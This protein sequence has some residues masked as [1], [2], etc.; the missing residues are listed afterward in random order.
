M[1]APRATMRLQLNAGFTFADAAT[2]LPYI[3]ALGVSHVYASP[4][5][6]ARL[7][8]MHGYDTIDPTRVNPELGAEEGLRQLVGEL[9]RHGMGL[10]VDIV[11]NHMATGSDNAWWMD[12]LARGRDSRYA[13]Y[14][15][16]DWAPDDPHLRG[17]VLSDPR[18]ALWRGFGRRRNRTAQRQR[19]QHLYPVFRPRISACGRQLR[20]R[21]AGF[22]CRLRSGVAAGRERLHRCSKSSAIVWLGGGSRMTKSIGAVSSTSTS[23]S[24]SAW[25]MTKCSRPFT[26]HC[27][28]FTPRVSSTACASTTSTASRGRRS[29]AQAAGAPA[30]A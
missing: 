11:P 9:R 6:T 18:P 5:M 4:I 21:R 13:R 16:I 22:V 15:D 10:I 8:S 2:L 17:K 12:V 27:S 20:S 19:R 14:F 23:L 30:R 25:R 26:L 28:G 1:S 24:P 7:G 3:S 29:T